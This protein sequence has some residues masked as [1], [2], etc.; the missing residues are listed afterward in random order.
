M[1]QM[2]HKADFI[3]DEQEK[4]WIMLLPYL[5]AEFLKELKQTIIRENLRKLGN[6][7]QNKF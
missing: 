4:N 7:H 1:E 5:S 3:P 6:K 2:I